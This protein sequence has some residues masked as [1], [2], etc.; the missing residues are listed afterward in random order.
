MRKEKSVGSLVAL[1]LVAAVAVS[2]CSSSQP[3]PPA[4]EA[5]KQAPKEVTPQDQVKWYQDCWSDFNEHKWD[6]FKKCYADNATSLQGGYGK[7]SVSG[8]DGIVAAS[9]DFAKS[10][11]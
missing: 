10:F 4:N 8:A 9:Q 5:A 6:E 3:T 1:L 11:P 7:P 2:A